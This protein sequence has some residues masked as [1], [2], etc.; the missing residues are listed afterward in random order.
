MA[1]H[2]KKY[3]ADLA[4]VDLDKEYS[5]R[6]AVALAKETSTT[7]RLLP[8]ALHCRMEGL[9]LIPLL[10]ITTGMLARTTTSVAQRLGAIAFAGARMGLTVGLRG[11]LRAGSVV[12]RQGPGAIQAS[13]SAVRRGVK[14]GRAATGSAGEIGDTLG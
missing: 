8:D 11:S 7:R 4:K 9:D 10:I 2:G 3:Q 5:T 1:K 6:E 12:R 14:Y 13:G